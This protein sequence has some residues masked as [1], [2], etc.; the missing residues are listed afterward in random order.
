MKM[1]KMCAAQSLRINQLPD[2]S[3]SQI[4]PNL[5]EIACRKLQKFNAQ[6]IAN[7]AWSFGV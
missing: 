1:K 3:I 6:G 4:M 7:M 5:A 2:V